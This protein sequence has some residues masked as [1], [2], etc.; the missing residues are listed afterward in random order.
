MNTILTVCIG[1]ICRSPVAEGLL[2][3]A[4]PGKNVFSAGLGALVGHE[5][6]PTAQE[7]ARQHGLDISSH[8]AQQLTSFLCRQADLILVMESIHKQEVEAR[9]PFTKGKVH[10]LGHISPKERIEIADPYRQP[11]EAFEIA[12]DAITRGAAHWAGLIQRL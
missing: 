6:E 4:L 1:N 12:H 7:I 11:R 2:K 10:C 5:A 8:R 9:Y 3:K